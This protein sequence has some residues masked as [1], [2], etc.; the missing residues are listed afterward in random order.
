MRTVALVPLLAIVCAPL[1]LEAQPQEERLEEELTL[2]QMADLA[3]AL[4]EGRRGARLGVAVLRW[5]EGPADG[6]EV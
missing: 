1:I 2:E 5:V 4:R 6:V 3:L